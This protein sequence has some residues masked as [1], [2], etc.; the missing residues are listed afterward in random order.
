[1][2]HLG[3]ICKINGAE[4]EPVDC[5]TGGS[6]CQDLSI[7]GKRAGL[8]GERSGL[9]ME[10]VRIVKEMR[11]RDRRNG[12]ADN[13]VRPRFLVWE[14]VVGA[15]S[16]NKGKDFAAVLEKI[17]RIA[18]PGFSLSGLPEKWK[19]T[20]AGAI[21]GDGWSIAWRTH[22]AQYWGVPQRRR[23]ISVVAD[24]GGQSAGEILFDRRCNHSR[25][26]YGVQRIARIFP[27]SFPIASCGV[28]S[29]DTVALQAENR[30]IV[31]R[32]QRSTFLRLH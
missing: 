28:G 25:T 24:F 14:N 13:M 21:D 4:I 26:I 22:D 17:A 19:W 10:Q 30:L 27:P 3:D 31:A 6:P 9:F 32:A 20:K 5:I 12:R 8:A 7:A 2:K 18:E 16:S 15:F 23:R 11:E 1:M 29:V